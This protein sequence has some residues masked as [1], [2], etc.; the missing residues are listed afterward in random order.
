MYVIYYVFYRNAP[1]PRVLGSISI[2][3]SASGWIQQ[4]R[5]NTHNKSNKPYLPRDVVYKVTA[6][7][8]FLFRLHKI[9]LA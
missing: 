2:N 6:L 4:G 5:I 3:I 9:K 8:Y 1:F 7:L